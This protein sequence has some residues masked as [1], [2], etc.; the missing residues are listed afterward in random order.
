MLLIVLRTAGG[1]RC[2]L[3][4]RNALAHFRSQLGAL[5]IP[6]PQSSCSVACPAP[7]P[8]AWTPHHSV[9]AH[10]GQVM[11]FFGG[12]ETVSALRNEG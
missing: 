12:V 1:E 5:N 11:I 10:A 7:D 2:V 4:S 3:S 8:S 9:G 6:P